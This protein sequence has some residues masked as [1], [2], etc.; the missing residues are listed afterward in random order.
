MAGSTA[1]GISFGI[2]STPSIINNII[3]ASG[4]AQTYG[5][6]ERDSCKPQAVQ[7]NDFTSFQSPP[8]GFYR[9]TTGLLYTTIAGLQDSFSGL[10]EREIACSGNTADTPVFDTAYRLTTG[11][12]LSISKGGMNLAGEGFSTDKDGATRTPPWS[13]GAYEYDN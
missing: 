9:P 13:I 2:G 6:N 8:G 1:Y 11:T 7:N 10:P 3:S 4:N 12:P 5:I